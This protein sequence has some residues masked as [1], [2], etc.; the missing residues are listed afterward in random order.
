MVL[1]VYHFQKRAF[2][3][4]AEKRGAAV[5]LSRGGGTPSNTMWP[6]PRFTSVPSGILIHPAVWSQ[7]T[8]A[9]TW[10]GVGVPISLGVA[11]SPSNTES[12]GPRP[13]SVSSGILVHP[14]VWPQRTLAANWGLCPFSGGGAGSPSNAMSRRPRPTSAP[15]RILIHAVVWPP[16]PK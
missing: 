15:S 11:G 6:G 16:S 13:T 10:V 7:Q 8:W 9:K 1:K 3:L 12:P 5:P 14:A 2:L 4:T